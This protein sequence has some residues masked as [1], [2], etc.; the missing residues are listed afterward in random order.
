MSLTV[1][2]P[3]QIALPLNRLESTNSHFKKLHLICDVL[4]GCFRLYGH[5]CIKISESE[6]V[7]SGSVEQ[8][9]ETLKQK[10]SHGLWSATIS[11]LVKE[12]DKKKSSLISYFICIFL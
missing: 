10:D 1:N 8:T 9:I 5:S 6:G 7:I 12:L 2:F 3:V 4:L 11:E